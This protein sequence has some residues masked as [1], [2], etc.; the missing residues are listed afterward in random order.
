MW[1]LAGELVVLWIV[2]LLIGLLIG[3]L[4]FGKLGKISWKPA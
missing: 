2:A 3:W 1:Y 4:L